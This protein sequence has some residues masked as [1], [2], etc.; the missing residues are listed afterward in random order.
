[1]LM[2][3]LN[4]TPDSFHAGG[5]TMHVQAAVDHALAMV[6]QG[7]DIIDVGGESTRPGAQRV[8]AA[9]QIRRVVPVIQGIRAHS[10]VPISVDTT[11]A[12][13]AEAAIRAG[14][15]MVNDVSGATEDAALL[16]LVARS[17]ASVVLMHRLTTPD[18]DHYSHQYETAPSY[19]DVV[20][21]VAAHLAQRAR[22]AM[23]AGV[24]A[25]RVV[26]D[27][28]FG[29]GKSVAQNFELLRRLREITAMDHPVLVGVSR[30]SFL[31]AA[32]GDADPSTRLPATLAAGFA[33][34][35]S[36]AAI[37]R[38]HDVAPHAQIRAVFR[39]MRGC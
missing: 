11:L 19:A 13:V 24:S 17:G 35:Q 25:Q 20:I 32:T 15:Q 21:D 29:F 16:P 4:C 7:A 5:R 12:S 34:M 37:L 36:G 39:S 8:D 22:V 1:M 14:A 31:G 2:G 18:Q 9:E 38:V 6:Q 10:S 33:A 30:K 28:G 3:I 23:D 27:P 26:L